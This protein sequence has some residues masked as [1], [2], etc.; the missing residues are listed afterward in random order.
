MSSIVKRSSVE[1]IKKSFMAKTLLVEECKF[2]IHTECG[3]CV[4]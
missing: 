1:P 2:V 3:K 4:C